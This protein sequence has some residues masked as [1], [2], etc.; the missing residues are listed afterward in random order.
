[1][2]KIQSEKKEYYTKNNKLG[3]NLLKISIKYWYILQL[4]SLILFNCH[5]Q[6]LT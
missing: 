6:T 5:V 2:F 4:N 1:M 3:I